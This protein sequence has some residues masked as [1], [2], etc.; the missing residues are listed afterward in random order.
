MEKKFEA[1]KRYLEE[2]THDRESEREE[3]QQMSEL[4][5]NQLEELKK[6]NAKLMEENKLIMYQIDD[7]TTR[8]SSSEDNELDLTQKWEKTK[9]ELQSSC[10]KVRKTWH[11]FILKCR[12]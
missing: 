9:V 5:Q 4:M 7:L 1:N 3:F 8:L 12:W 11:D 2:Q 6:D 10:D